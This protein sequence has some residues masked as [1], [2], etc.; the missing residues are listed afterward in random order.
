MVVILKQCD[1]LFQYVN[2][3]LLVSPPN[4]FILVGAIF[5]KV[6]NL[7]CGSTISQLLPYPGAG[8]S[9]NPYPDATYAAGRAAPKA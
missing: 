2:F 1:T 8:L 5:L 9:T 7:Y 3:G 6:S 4:S